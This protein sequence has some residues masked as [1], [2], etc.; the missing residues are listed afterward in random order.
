[1]TL[2]QKRIKQELERR[3]Y[4]QKKTMQSE[5]LKFQAMWSLSSNKIVQ[6]HTLWIGRKGEICRGRRL[7]TSQDI[8]RW[9]I[10][11]EIRRE[12]KANYTE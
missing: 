9:P 2:T 3:G 6:S 8:N 12:A 7:H 10:G 1:M 4:E 5:Y 11:I